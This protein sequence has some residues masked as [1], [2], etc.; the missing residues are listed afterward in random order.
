M[1]LR[2]TVNKMRSFRSHRSAKEQEELRERVDQRGSMELEPFAQRPMLQ[3]TESNASHTSARILAA[4]NTKTT[5]KIL[6]FL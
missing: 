1:T 6:D 5:W 2:R 3:K 4:K